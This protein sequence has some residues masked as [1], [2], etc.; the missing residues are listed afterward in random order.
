[1]TSSAAERWARVKQTQETLLAH[2]LETR[3]GNCSC[4]W[5]PSSDRGAQREHAKHVAEV[6]VG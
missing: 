4:G 6:L 2:L 5:E 1:M 3:T